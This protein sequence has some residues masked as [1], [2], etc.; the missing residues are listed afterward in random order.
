MHCLVEVHTL[1]EVQRA[2]SVGARII[3]INSRDL[4]T[5]QI[6]P[7]LIRELRPLIPKDT[8][9]VAESGIHTSADARHLARYDVQAMLV[10]ESLVTSL[11]IPSQ[12]RTLLK[13]ANEKD[14]KSVV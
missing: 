8:V 7:D 13:G 9:V 2:I 10:G 5:L 12:I 14:R 3:G 6:H 4:K 1:E 11:D